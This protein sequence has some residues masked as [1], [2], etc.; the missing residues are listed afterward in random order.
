MRSSHSP[1][2]AGHY[3]AETMGAARFELATFT[4]SG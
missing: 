3:P 2:F 1:G 4:V